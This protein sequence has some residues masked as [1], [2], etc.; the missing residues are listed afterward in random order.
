MI[1]SVIIHNPCDC[2]K[3]GIERMV[4]YFNHYER[5]LCP[6]C[7]Q[8]MK[9][10]FDVWKPTHYECRNKQCRMFGQTIKPFPRMTT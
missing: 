4:L 7:K 8:L 3:E 5:L 10:M 2:S 1:E 9:R 6:W